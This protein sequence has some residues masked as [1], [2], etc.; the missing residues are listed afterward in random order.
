MCFRRRKIFGCRK[1]QP[2]SIATLSTPLSK[3]QM[4]PAN[5]FEE[6]E[7][8]S[9]ET[10]WAMGNVEHVSKK[11]KIF[12]TFSTKTDQKNNFGKNYHSTPLN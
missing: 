4:H 10:Q 5:T 12:S 1:F 9:Y 3:K 6:N 7:R 8:Q 11:F 2:R